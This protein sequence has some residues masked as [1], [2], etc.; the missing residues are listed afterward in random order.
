MDNGADSY[1][2]FLEGDKNAISE[3]VSEYHS[4]LVLFLNTMTNNICLSEELAEDVFCELMIK[5]PQFGG[6][7]S[8]RTWLYSVARYTALHCMKKRSRLEN[9]S[10][11]EHYDLADEKNIETE[12]IRNERK[13]QI[14]KALKA[15]NRDYSQVL[16]LTYF[17]GFSNTETAKIM[18]KNNRQIENLLYRAKEALRKELEREGFVYE[19]L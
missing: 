17:E 5:K 14:H 15:I 2:R 7:S 19:E 16:F 6:K 13:M 10:I 12:Y 18:K 8:F 1:R 9:K 11:D 4:G 3:I